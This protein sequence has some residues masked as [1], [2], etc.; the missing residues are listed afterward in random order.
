M[1]V[2]LTINNVTL[3]E[4]TRYHFRLAPDFRAGPL[5]ILTP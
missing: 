4:F 5:F 1:H 3:A 2:L